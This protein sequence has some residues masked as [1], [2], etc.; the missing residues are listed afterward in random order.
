MRRAAALAAA[1]LLAACGGGSADEP[2]AAPATIPEV[3]DVVPLAAG[4]LTAVLDEEGL[5]TGAPIELPGVDG[6][7]YRIDVPGDDAVGLW[8]SLRAL[9]HETGYFPVIAGGMVELGN[10]PYDQAQITLDNARF[11]VDQDGTTAADVVAAAGDIDLDAWWD[12]RQAHLEVPDGELAIDG[13]LPSYDWPKDEF[14]SDEDLVSGEPLDQVAVFLVPTATPWEVPAML[15][16]GGWNDVP[17]PTELVAVFEHWY[18]VYGAEPV[19]MTDAVVEM[20]VL[21]PPTDDDAAVRL[22]GEQ[23]LVAPDIVW[24]GTG[25]LA[26]LASAVLDAPV[27]FF[28]W[29]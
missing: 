29:D 2:D 7:G 6:E 17:D 19:A 27:W 9:V 16:W 14:I 20:R 4:V 23:F 1:G 28:W 21:R 3:V 13:E 18:E 8:E 10:R 15:L 12:D 11:A 5:P 25:E 22:A 26:T 24:Q